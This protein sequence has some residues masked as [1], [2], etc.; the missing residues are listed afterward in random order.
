MAWAYPGPGGP[1]PFPA[2]PY[3]QATWPSIPI[4]PQLPYGVVP[5]VPHEPEPTQQQGGGAL[6]DPFQQAEHDIRATVA[7]P[8]WPTSAPIHRQQALAVRLLTL[9]DQ[10]WWLYGAW[11]RWYRWHPAD[12]HWFPC[13]PP[14]DPDVRRSALYPQPGFAPP[15][16]PAELLPTGPDF[17]FDLGTPLAVAGRPLSGAALYRL[18]KIVTEAALAPAAD[19][20]LGWNH[21]LHGTP[22]TVAAAWSTLVW[23]A[24]TPLFDPEVDGQLLELW[25][26][27]LAQPPAPQGRFR[28]LTA[29]PLTAITGLYVE[30]LT[31]GRPD[32]AGHLARHMAMTA[33]ALR[34]DPRFH[35]RAT[36]L[37]AM[38]EPLQ[39]NPAA[40]APALVHGPQGVEREWLG[41]C[42]AAL[43]TTLFSDT[44]P[45]EHFQLAFYDLATTLSPL[46]AAQSTEPRHLAVALLAADLGGYR[47]D[48]AEPIGR[49]LDPE[50]RALLTG[51]LE[52]PGHGLR[53]LWPREGDLPDALRPADP[54]TALR[55]LSAMAALDFAWCHLAN[56]LPIPATGFPTPDAFA[57]YLDTEKTGSSSEPVSPPS[58]NVEAQPEN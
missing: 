19:Y 13:P 46:A 12:G 45:G 39:L 27:Y 6:P 10:T 11:A 28:W 30:R 4:P 3:T 54:S 40:D 18:Q 43:A 38:I 17:S 57:R 55:I 41:R 29:P 7:A 24:D 52:V 51:I 2:S 36:T 44:A 58:P 56:G 42:P 25:E 8:W 22:S 47:A 23:C 34:D 21:F 16:I 1:G 26:P 5:P 49:W 9:P 35:A 20:P 50:L 31:G 33:Q 37:L 53:E 48:L 14:Q 15:A 32:A